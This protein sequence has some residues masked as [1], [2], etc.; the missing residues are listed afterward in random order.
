VGGLGKW[1][2]ASGL[3]ALVCILQFGCEFQVARSY[4]LAARLHVCVL[5]LFLFFFLANNNIQHVST[6]YIAHWAGQKLRGWRVP[7]AHAPCLLHEEEEEDSHLH[8][9]CKPTHSA[10][11]RRSVACASCI[12]H[13]NY[14]RQAGMSGMSTRAFLTPR[15]ADLDPGSLLKRAVLNLSLDIET[16]HTY[17]HRNNMTVPIELTSH[18]HKASSY[19]H[20]T[21]TNTPYTPCYFPHSGTALPHAR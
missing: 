17:K 18:Q 15:S 6:L 20:N 9:S 2:I 11:C 3:A 7:H 12:I 8:M 14:K 19:A 5:V 1:P 16:A 10:Q 4:C 21:Q 13:Y